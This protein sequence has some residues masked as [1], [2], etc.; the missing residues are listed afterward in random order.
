MGDDGEDNM[1]ASLTSVSHF[2]AT[3]Q[4][5]ER[6]RT[7]LTDELF[8]AKPQ[9]NRESGPQRSE[10]TDGGTDG[11]TRENVAPHYQARLLQ[12]Q[13]QMHHRKSALRTPPLSLS[14]RILVLG[15]WE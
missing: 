3:A 14:V 15:E 2:E 9:D 13:I 7:T 1:R 12:R 8:Q 10:W 6:R 4:F 5:S 11:L